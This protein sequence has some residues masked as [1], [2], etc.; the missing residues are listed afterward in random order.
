[1]PG[2]ATLARTLLDRV[3]NTAVRE[4]E[5]THRG[6]RIRLRKGAGVVDRPR[7]VREIPATV[8]EPA[9]VD[10]S[11]GLV[12]I[13]TPVTG[14]FYRAPIPGGEPFVSEGDVVHEGQVIG[15]V[16]AM[17]IFNEVVAHMAGKLVRFIVQDG[18]E[19]Q[20]GGTVSLIRPQDAATSRSNGPTYA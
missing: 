3:R 2:L 11:A 14:V 13:A 20:E 7:K 12:D 8:P 5:V 6:L 1:M 19:V 9:A 18:E 17:K 16:E 4:I 10:E 15:V